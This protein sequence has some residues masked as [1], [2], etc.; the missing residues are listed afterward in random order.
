MSGN[1]YNQYNT[2]RRQRRLNLQNAV[3]KWIPRYPNV[4]VRSWLI[5]KWEYEGGNMKLLRSTLADLRV[6]G[7]VSRV[8][9]RWVFDPNDEY[10]IKNPD[11]PSKAHKTFYVE[12]MCPRYKRRVKSGHNR[13]PD[14]Y[15]KP[16]PGRSALRAEREWFKHGKPVRR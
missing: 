16:P 15:K 4:I 3:L 2:L 8:N 5:N 13:I 9:Y 6:H 14:N 1:I 10:L 12:D 7:M 11:Y